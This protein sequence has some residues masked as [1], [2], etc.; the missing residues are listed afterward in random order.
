MARIVIVGGSFG[1]L[2]TALQLKQKLKKQNHITLISSDDQFVFIPSLPWLALG[3]RKPQ[4]ITIGLKDYL[5]CRD[6][7]FIHDTVHQIE[8]EQQI[9]VTARETVPYD[10]LVLATGPHLD[11]A[12]VPGLGPETGYT[13]SIF[14]L[15]HAC[16]A[17]DSWQRYMAEGGPVVIGATQG[18]SCIGPAYEM[19]FEI[20]HLLRKMG[21]RSKTPLCF[22]TAEPYLGHFG[23]GG[24]GKSRRLMED[25]FAEKDIKAFCSAAVDEITPGRVKLNDGTELPFNYSMFAPPFRGVDAI[26]NSGL[27]NPKGWLMVDEY[28]RLPK[29]QNIYGVGV[30]VGIMPVEPTPVPTGV[31]KTGNMTTNM[32][33]LAAHNIAADIQGGSKIAYPV[34]E[35][36]VV[37]L[38]DMGDSASLMVAKPALPPRQQTILKKKRWVRWAKLGFERYF[39]TKMKLGATYLPG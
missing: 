33:K 15:K 27:G 4:D 19:I 39:M 25:E 34:T 16:R 38:A 6:I 3:W 24:V 20:D 21:R 17:Y 36:G 9:V 26:I 7:N 10:Y 31:P 11:F 18:V 32:A 1:G 12:A 14:T 22:V 5:S 37:C 8:P 13:E 2:T 30:S 35:I 29:H 28:Y 23:L